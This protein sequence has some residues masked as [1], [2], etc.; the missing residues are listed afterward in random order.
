MS[1]LTMNIEA[2]DAVGSNKA[3][4][5]RAEKIVPG[6]IYSRGEE[7]K[8]ISVDSREFHRVY[9][10][11]GLSSVI[12]LDLGGETIPVVIKEVQKHPF[13]EQLIHIDFQKINMD[14][15][16]KMSVPVVLLNR[17]SIKLQPSTLVQQLDEVEIECLPG[18]LPRTAD[19]DVADM[20]F[21]TPKLVKD[22]DIANKEGITMLI[23]LEETVCSLVPPMAEE[24]LEEGS[25][26][27]ITE[28]EVIGEENSEE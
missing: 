8:M 3:K 12:K 24:E 25:E 10:Q 27:E 14:E 16:I 2:R 28:P 7:T 21:N 19:V 5:L 18:A 4:K 13:K 11:A 1:N 26:D 6:V 23:D 20:D 9:V 15:T 17:D 22:L